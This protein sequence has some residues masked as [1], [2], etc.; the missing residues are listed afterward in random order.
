MYE[1]VKIQWKIV[2]IRYTNGPNSWKNFEFL[3]C[4][5]S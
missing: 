2:C 3:E 1:I 5:L 4:T